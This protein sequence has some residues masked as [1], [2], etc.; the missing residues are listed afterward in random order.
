MYFKPTWDHG[1][2]VEHNA[3]VLF[4]YINI[5]T[6]NSIRLNVENIFVNG[7]K[8]WPLKSQIPYS[9]YVFIPMV[10]LLLLILLF[11]F[12]LVFDKNKSEYLFLMFVTVYLFA[13][14]NLIELAEN[15]RYR[16]MID[17]LI[18]MVF[19]N[20]AWMFLRRNNIKRN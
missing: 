4:P 18:Y 9:S 5:M 7:D 3:K 11:H 14:S 6:L 13:V 15:D 12:R 16:V 17:P 1:F 8:P 20:L 2:G 10:Y 19:I